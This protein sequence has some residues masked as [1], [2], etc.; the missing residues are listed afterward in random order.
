MLYIFQETVRYFV[1][2]QSPAPSTG[3]MSYFILMADGRI[4]VNGN[5][6]DSAFIG[7]FF[8]VCILET[9]EVCLVCLIAW[10]MSTISGCAVYWHIIAITVT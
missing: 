6:R 4:L 7:D 10:F 5:L 8:T 1:E 9:S 3:A 2:T